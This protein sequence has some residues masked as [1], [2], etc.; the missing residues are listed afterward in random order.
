MSRLTFTHLTLAD[1]ESQLVGRCMTDEACLK[2]CLETLPLD[3][4]RSEQ[5]QDLA[6]VF[7]ALA[8]RLERG[9]YNPATNEDELA[10]ALAAYDKQGDAA[11]WRAYLEELWSPWMAMPTYL[12]GVLDVV[13]QAYRLTDNAAAAVRA[14]LQENPI[15][16]DVGLEDDLWYRVRESVVARRAMRYRPEQPTFPPKESTRKGGRF[17]GGIPI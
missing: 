16:A 1:V 8:G 12:V 2:L 3:C 11:Y 14:M 5:G 6:R 9:A 15:C 4:W 17:V 10:V 13:T 7:Y